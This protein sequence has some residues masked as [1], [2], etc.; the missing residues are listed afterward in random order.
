MMINLK[1]KNV[2][3]KKEKEFMHGYQSEKEKEVYLNHSLF[4]LQLE[5]NMIFKKIHI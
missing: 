3:Q 4:K 1:C 2:T 5:E